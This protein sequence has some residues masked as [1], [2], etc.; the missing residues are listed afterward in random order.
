MDFLV[1]TLI[2]MA[3]LSITSQAPTEPDITTD[4]EWQQHLVHMCKLN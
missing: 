4:G 2:L 3:G 1:I